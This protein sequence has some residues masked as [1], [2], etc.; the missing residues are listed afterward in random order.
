M[1]K[2]SK[3]HTDMLSHVPTGLNLLVEKI[4]Q[5]R[6]LYFTG[7]SLVFYLHSESKINMYINLTPYNLDYNKTCL[8]FI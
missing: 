4:L 5:E 7:K 1:T 6:K 2:S 8:G 3:Y